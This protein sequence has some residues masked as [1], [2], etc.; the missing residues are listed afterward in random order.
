MVLG[1]TEI[2]LLVTPQDLPSLPLYDTTAQ[3][4]ERAVE[5]AL[6]LRPLPAAREPLSTR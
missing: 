5:L 4:V 1:C 6:G 3:H 2:G